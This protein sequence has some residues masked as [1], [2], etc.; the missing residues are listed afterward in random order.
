[1]KKTRNLSQCRAKT[2][3]G[4]PCRAAAVSNGLCLFHGNPNLASELGRKG[5][6]SRRH[7]SVETADPLPSLDTMKSVHEMNKRLFEEVYS[8]ETPRRDVS[9]LVRILKSITDSI[10]FTDHEQRL[11]KLEEARAQSENGSGGPEGP[12]AV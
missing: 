2:K 10:R 11:L 12:V 1:V 5:G 6:R 9:T 8:G 7:V 3:D 4:K